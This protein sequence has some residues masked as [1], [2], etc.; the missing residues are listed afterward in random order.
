MHGELHSVKRS[1]LK[2][3]NSICFS[4]NVVNRNS[5]LPLQTC[6]PTNTLIIHTPTIRILFTSNAIL[7]TLKNQPNDFNYSWHARC[8]LQKVDLKS[9]CRPILLNL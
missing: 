8:Q 7:T 3:G 9:T 1:H 5:W 6:D 4:G 2:N